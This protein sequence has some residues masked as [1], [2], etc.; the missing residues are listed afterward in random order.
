MKRKL[1]PVLSVLALAFAA[2]VWAAPWGGFSGS[3]ACKACHAEEYASWRESYHS[4]M[5]RTREEGILKGVVDKWTSDG[6]N[7]GPTT[8]NGTGE[9]FKLEDVQNVIGSRWKQRFL[10]KNAQTGGLQFMN[11]QFNRMSGLWENYGNKNDWNTICGTCH[12]TGYR[13]TAYDPA[14]P[15]AQKTDW[16]ELAVG[17]ETCHGAGAK[18]VASKAIVDIYNPGKK[19]FE[20]QTRM[21][22][23]CHNRV[24]NKKFLTAQGNNRED[25][26]APVVGE[27]RNPGDDWRTWYPELL[28]APGI[29]A[30][31]KLDVEHEGDLKGAFKIDDHSKSTG[32]YEE[33]KHHEQ[34][35]GFLQ[36]THY[37]QEHMS[38]VTCH[39]PHAGKGKIK[40]VAKDGCITCHDASFTVEKYMPNTGKTADNLFVRSHTFNKTPRPS[41]PGATGTPE[42]YK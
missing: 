30:E 23:Y 24:E 13:I 3:E 16:V 14:A 12:T 29:H 37:T 21:C 41:G 35:Q 38:C 28:V 36:S 15:A 26:P 40:K 32:V 19:P 39:S 4:K 18:H 31:D 2:Q 5:V 34:Y 11:K 10:V 9:A 17:C 27:T 25:I 6:T 33:G 20:E 42:Y 1:V 22:G 7:P 8:G